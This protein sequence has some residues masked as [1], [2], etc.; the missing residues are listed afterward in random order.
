MPE[1]S[2]PG[3][4]ARVLREA[5]AHGALMSLASDG[6]A[7]LPG[8]GPLADLTMV[9]KDNVHVAG[10]PNTACTRALE[11]FVPAADAPVVARLRESGVRLLGKAAMHELSLGVTGMDHGFGTVTNAHD[12]ARIAGGSSSGVA[13]AVALGVDAG[14]GT[15]TGGSVTIPAAVNGV[16]GFRPTTSRYPREAITPLDPSRDTPGII[17]HTVEQI[18]RIDAVLA[19]HGDGVGV[20]RENA[21]PLLPVTPPRLGVPEWFGELHPRTR[22]LFDRALRALERTGAVLVPLPRGVTDER[23]ATEARLGPAAVSGAIRRA[24][25]AY[26]DEYLPALSLAT[27]AERVVNPEVR[28]ALH[29]ML[30]P[31]DPAAD[32]AAQEHAQ[33]VA[34]RLRAAHVSA[35]EEFGLQGI[36]RPTTPLPAI[37]LEQARRGLGGHETVFESYTRLT[38]HA[39]VVG[40]PSLSIPMAASGGELPHGLSID[41][42]PGGDTELIAV[43][44]FMERALAG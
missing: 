9:V 8:A 14:L 16:C 1:S 39:C 24:L 44:A 11:S 21:L 27:L 40:A 30:D 5:D 26:L 37:T 42:A 38:A 34:R 43:G 22:E 13:V 4:L 18:A 35:L 32:H 36:V 31:A 25:G 17:A 29:G 3:E 7:A 12:P 33:R 2:S 20:H 10:L 6:E 19:P 41:G 23:V 15:D 28:E